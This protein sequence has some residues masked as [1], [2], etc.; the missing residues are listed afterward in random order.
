MSLFVGELF[1]VAV[2][3]QPFLLRFDEPFLR[4]LP[5]TL[6]CAVSLV[7]LV[8]LVAQAYFLPQFITLD[9]NYYLC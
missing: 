4:R 3:L 2:L 9:M 5:A 8:L 1:A 7:P 6:S